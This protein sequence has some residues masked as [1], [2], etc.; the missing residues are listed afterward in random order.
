MISLPPYHTYHLIF[1]GSYGHCTTLPF[2]HTRVG[3]LPA[4][5]GWFCLPPVLPPALPFTHIAHTH[6]HRHTYTYYIPPACYIHTF[7]PH[8]AGWTPATC[9]RDCQA[10]SPHTTRFTHTRTPPTTFTHRCFCQ[11][12]PLYHTHTLY[13][14]FFGLRCL[15]PHTTATL[16]GALALV[17]RAHWMPLP[18]PLP[19]LPYLPCYPALFMHCT[20]FT[21]FPYHHRCGSCLC[22]VPCGQ[23]YVCCCCVYWFSFTA[24]W[25]A[26]C[27]PLPL[28]LCVPRTPAPLPGFTFP[29]VAHLYALIYLHAALHHTPFTADRIAGLCSSPHTTTYPGYGCC[30]LRTTTIYYHTRLPH[31]TYTTCLPTA[32]TCHHPFVPP[33]LPAPYYLVLLFT[34]YGL[35]PTGHYHGWFGSSVL[36]ICCTYLP[37]YTH[38]ALHTTGNIPPYPSPLLTAVSTVAPAIQ[39]TPAFVLPT[40]AACLP[41]CL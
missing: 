15:P 3:W 31:F 41:C 13:A 18:L 24:L 9:H 19:P 10:G 6:T 5:A 38:G 34:C 29:A 32:F 23:F 36:S 1:V 35:L 2:T 27:L 12:Y 20:V 22:W 40:L 11:F 33:Y 37:T 25:I 17:L 39:H 4:H 14:F 28:C 8:R 26:A 21:I 16:Y 7:V 30:L